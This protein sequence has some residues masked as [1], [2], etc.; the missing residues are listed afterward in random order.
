MAHPAEEFVPSVWFKFDEAVVTAG[1]VVT[2]SGSGTGHTGGSWRYVSNYWLARQSKLTPWGQ[3]AVSLDPLV[4]PNSRARLEVIPTLGVYAGL[5][6]S[7]GTSKATSAVLLLFLDIPE[8]MGESGDRLTEDGLV[9]NVESG[10]A[11]NLEQ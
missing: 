9:R 2:N 4:S 7:G 10:L 8:V 1:T 6:L 5:D 11:R 3:Y